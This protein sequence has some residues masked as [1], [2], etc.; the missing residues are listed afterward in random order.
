MLKQ[1]H[2]VGIFNRTSGRAEPQQQFDCGKMT[3][4]WVAGADIGLID[5]R[6][7]TMGVSKSLLDCIEQGKIEYLVCSNG[8]P[9][10]AH[11]DTGWVLLHADRPPRLWDA[12]MEAFHDALVFAGWTPK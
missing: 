7:H 3:G 2:T 9:L 11:G 1:I 6:Y 10:A 5:V 4:R 8:I 12:H